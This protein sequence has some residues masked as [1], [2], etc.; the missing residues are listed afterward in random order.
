MDFLYPRNQAFF[1]FLSKKT[2]K[3]TNSKTSF[4][5]RDEK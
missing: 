2:F 3:D 4:A 1:L 5:L